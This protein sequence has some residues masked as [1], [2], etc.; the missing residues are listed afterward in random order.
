M[1]DSAPSTVIRWLAIDGDSSES[2]RMDVMALRNEAKGRTTQEYLEEFGYWSYWNWGRPDEPPED[3]LARAE[4]RLRIGDEHGQ[5]RPVPREVLERG[6]VYLRATVSPGLGPM[7]ADYDAL[8]VEH[9]LL[10]AD[11]DRAHQL[12]ALEDA[13]GRVADWVYGPPAG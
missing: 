2:A 1:D 10:P 12:A 4:A 9:D 3:V 5:P 11:E 7:Q 6:L 8:R 13:M